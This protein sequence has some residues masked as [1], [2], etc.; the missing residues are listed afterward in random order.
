MSGLSE[1]NEQQSQNVRPYRA[2][3]DGLRAVAILLVAAFHASSHWVPAGFVGVDVFFVISGY[4]ITGILLSDLERNKFSYKEFYARRVRRIFPAL[5]LTLFVTIAV[6]RVIM[7]PA[8]FAALTNDAIAGVLFASNLHILAGKGYFHSFLPSGLEHLWSIAV[9]EQF[10]V[11]W[12]VLVATLYSRGERAL[13]AVLWLIMASSFALNL[14]L[15]GTRPEAAYLLPFTRAWQLAAGAQ[16]AASQSRRGSTGRLRE[17]L[18]GMFAFTAVREL[19]SLLGIALIFAATFRLNEVGYPGWYALVPTAGTLLL[20]AAGPQALFNRY[21]LS[22]KPAVTL[23][24]ISYPLYLWHWPIL[25]Y[26]CKFQL[27]EAWIG[28]RML[29]RAACILAA[30]VLAALTYYLLEKPLRKKNARAACIPIAASLLLLVPFGLLLRGT[31]EWTASLQ[32]G[33]QRLAELHEHALDTIRVE[34]CLLDLNQPASMLS[35]ECI[36]PA[37]GSGKPLI[38]LMGDSLVLHL[39]MGL[40]QVLGN[41]YRI[42]RLTAATCRPLLNDDPTNNPRCH[43]IVPQFI[44]RVKELQPQI[45]LVGANWF[46]NQGSKLDETLGVL[47]K[48]LNARIIVIGRTHEW[49]LPLY[50][51][52]RI[53]ALKD[54]AWQ[55]PERLPLENFPPNITRETAH[56]VD[57]MVRA[58]A[59]KHGVEFFSVYDSLCDDSGCLA[60]V[61]AVND[62][63]RKELTSW[64]ALHFTAGAS[65]VIARDFARQ[66]Q[67]DGKPGR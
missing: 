40:R 15:V 39:H 51:R 9:E 42:S 46:D 63:G 61:P 27:G 43:E 64:D 17:R 65:V 62:D 10:Y 53:D 48:T 36:E 44:E 7:L 23:G 67:L 2:D 3:V 34:H 59:E 26:L 6:A 57:A 45:L 8:E 29:L 18:A 31:A 32:P 41:D 56:R 11:I 38:A 60:T 35:S 14:A 55:P 47:T 33:M 4:L 37:D 12:P 66:F 5:A 50:A 20:I 49:Q 13:R 24:L 58:V 16:L 52:F 22:S 30:V 1:P 21:A 25:T 28:S 19:A 54:S